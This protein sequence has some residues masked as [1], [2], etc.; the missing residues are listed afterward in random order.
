MK[1]EFDVS[2]ILMCW[3]EAWDYLVM[4]WDQIFCYH[5]PI[6]KDEPGVYLCLFGVII[7]IRR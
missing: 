2:Q 3:R 7:Y 6:S 5:R 4:A 1:V